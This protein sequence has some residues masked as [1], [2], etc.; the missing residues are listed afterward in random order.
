MEKNSEYLEDLK[1]IK[2]VME[3][4][5]R[6]LSLSGL[7]GLIAGL[8]ALIGGSAALFLVSGGRLVLSEED[9]TGMTGNRL[10]LLLADVLAV[11]LIAMI[12]SVYFSYR[13][14]VRQG[15]KIW[16]PVS[17]R[18]LLHLL[19]PLSAGAAFIIILISKGDWQYVAPS[20]LIFYGLALVSSGKFTSGEVFWLG[21][22]ELL[23][24][25]VAMIFTGY[26]ILFWFFGFGILHIIYGLLL[27]R[28]YEG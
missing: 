11:L 18:M 19:I 27:F 5:S 8:A 25:L 28:K 12:S 16:T 2:R 26:S 1:T 9:I 7:S 17:K 13:R 24:G 3:E 20:M 15:L 21:L 14:S 10:L 22:A 23:T 6:F 4:S